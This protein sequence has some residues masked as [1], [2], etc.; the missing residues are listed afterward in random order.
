LEEVVSV[1]I[2]VP[3]E[4]K[5]GERRVALVPE[6]VA[7]LVA[8][9]HS[10][11][12]ESGAGTAAQMPDA[13]YA[14]AGAEILPDA[15]SVFD[16]ADMLLKVRAPEPDEIPLLQ[17]GIVLVAQMM[18]LVDPETA[19][20]VAETGAISF[21]MDLMPRITR[22]Q[23]MDVLSSMSTVAGYRAVL[24]GALLA[25]RFFPMLMT[26]AGT[27][28]PA[29][30]LIL[31]AGV[32]GLQ[33]I[34]TARRLGA[35]VQAFDVRPASREQVESLGASFL[36]LPVTDGEGEGGYARAMGADEEELERQA[37]AEPVKKADLVVSTAMVPGRRAPLLVN[38]E[39]VEAMHP[40][41]V[42]VDL[43][44]E[45]GGNCELTVPGEVVVSDGGVIIDGRLN[46]PSEMPL[47]ASQLFS[48]NLVTFLD[49][50][51][52][53]W[54]GDAKDKTGLGALPEGDEILRATCVSFGGALVHKATAERLASIER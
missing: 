20:R 5:P 14:A 17:P 38:R 2:G 54:I 27:I 35:V 31:G 19:A 25:E 23:S 51:F 53:A 9:G 33:A 44:A 21:S 28:P 49:H 7:K 22:A 13:V 34:A 3:R 36:S 39:M 29:K 11:G 41:A 4:T 45:T 37:L 32:A 12:I 1:Y 8:K 50:T 30:A 24:Q 15:Q 40:G 52:S 18:P 43:A 46:V 42:I 47:P 10:V 6:T 26:A 16:K 48:R